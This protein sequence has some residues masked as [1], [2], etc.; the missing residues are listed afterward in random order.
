MDI[1]WVSDAQ[2]VVVG[3]V[4]VTREQLPGD[5]DEEEAVHLGSE[6]KL[7]ASQNNSINNIQNF[8]SIKIFFLI[9]DL[10]F[11]L[12]LR[13]RNNEKSHWNI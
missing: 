13:H 2:A 12:L 11:V 8:N 5:R 3:Q 10:L 1:F 9:L 6:P 4:Y 7:L